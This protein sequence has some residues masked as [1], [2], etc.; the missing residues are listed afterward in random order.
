[1]KTQQKQSRGEVCS[2]QYVTDQVDLLKRELGDRTKI[3]GFL[4]KIQQIVAGHTNAQKPGQLWLSKYSCGVI[5]TQDFPPRLLQSAARSY[6]APTKTYAFQ[7]AICPFQGPYFCFNQ[8]FQEAR[9]LLLKKF[10]QAYSFRPAHLFRNLEYT[11]QTCI[12]QNVIKII[13]YCDFHSFC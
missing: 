4:S 10:Q 8:F 2:E 5:R 1:M 11:M 12:L 3:E 7:V 6:F 9:L 13:G